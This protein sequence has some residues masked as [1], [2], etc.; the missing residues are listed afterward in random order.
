M[1]K[2]AEVTYF[3]TNVI[4]IILISIKILAKKRSGGS[5]QLLARGRPTISRPS[6]AMVA[7][8]KTSLTLSRAKTVTSATT[9][10]TEAAS[11]RSNWLS[12]PISPNP[13]RSP[14]SLA[15]G[16]SSQVALNPSRLP[17]LRKLARMK[18]SLC[19]ARAP[20]SSRSQLQLKS[21]WTLQ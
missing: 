12:L 1:R 10:M 21:C 18:A 14:R 11:Q 8:A 3:P 7:P 6:P 16:K 17:S 5:S 2:S 13:T 9:G 20:T 4:G 15:P 19:P